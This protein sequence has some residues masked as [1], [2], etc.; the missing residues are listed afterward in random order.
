MKTP[1]RRQAN[2]GI[3]TTCSRD[4]ST[5]IP[6]YI[7]TVPRVCPPPHMIRAFLAFKGVSHHG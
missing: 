5:R 1:N 4:F 3:S 7:Q 6:P 2:S